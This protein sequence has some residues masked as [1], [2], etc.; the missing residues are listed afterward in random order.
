MA[1]RQKDSLLKQFPEGYVNAKGRVFPTKK[2]AQATAGKYKRPIV[3]PK[4]KTGYR[5]T[6]KKRSK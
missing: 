2:A 1:K 3:K 4:G 5:V 6:P